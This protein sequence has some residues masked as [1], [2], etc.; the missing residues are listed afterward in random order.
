MAKKHWNNIIRN[1]I[2]RRRLSDFA[3]FFVFTSI[4][5]LLVELSETHSATLVYD[6]QYVSVPEDKLLLGDPV[7]FINVKVKGGGYAIIKN[8][9]FRK[10]LKL[11]V[12]RIENKEGNF[13]LTP[14]YLEAAVKEQLSK[15]ITFINLQRNAIVLQLGQN[16]KKRIPVVP[17]LSISFERDFDLYGKLNIEPDSINVIGPENIVDTLSALKTNKIVLS[18]INADIF[19]ETNIQIPEAL[20]DVKFSNTKIIIRGRVVRFTEKIVEVPIII[21]HKPDNLIIRLFPEK[22][23]V[24]CIGSLA[25]LKK[26][27]PNDLMVTAD[28][29]EAKKTGV[30]I[31]EVKKYPEYLRSAE[32]VDKKV[33]FLIKKE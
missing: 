12:S 5:W 18:D 17:D 27:L 20:K 13:I 8:R 10:T 6:I 33:E 29:E 9:I 23:K 16:S 14:Q 21:T 31:P 19:S 22:V 4:L 3:V 7:N 30:L 24:K 32:I 2:K 26:V 15:D 1:L 28:F 25:D 11:D